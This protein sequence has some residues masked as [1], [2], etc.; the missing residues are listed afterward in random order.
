MARRRYLRLARKAKRS[1]RARRSLGVSRRRLKRWK[2]HPRRFV[3][4]K[5][6]HRRR[7][8]R[9][10]RKCFP[11]SATVSLA[12]G[13]TVTMEE[14]KHG[15]AVLT[16]GS[17]GTPAYA[18]VF[19]FGHKDQHTTA[20]FQCLHTASGRELCLTEDHFLL[21]SASSSRWADAMYTRAGSV[22]AGATLWEA[23]PDSPA[24]APTII[25]SVETRWMA[26]L[27]NPYTLG[28][29][30]I[31]VDGL[32]ASTHSHWFLDSSV[33]ESLSWALPHVYEAALA[34]AR[35]L[36]RLMGPK[37]AE[38]VQQRLELDSLG[39]DGQG[40]WG[41]VA[42][43]SALIASELPAITTRSL[44]VLGVHRSEL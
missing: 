10:K 18:E 28:G 27:Y 30:V 17:D 20:P 39:R 4:W 16:L 15:D 23:S 35:V 1:R 24:P 40:V 37:W 42:P 2:R 8:R 34:P 3:R 6:I 13:R 22:K 9:A 38:G 25:T 11:G 32:V 5:R 19:F 41:L 29:A 31:V 7:Y 26:G 14:L 21:A 44:A 12:S 33:A 43:Y 36:Y